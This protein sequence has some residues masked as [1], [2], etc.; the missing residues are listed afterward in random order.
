M[1]VDKKVKETYPVV[2]YDSEGRALKGVK[3]ERGSCDDCDAARVTDGKISGVQ[4]DVIIQ[5]KQAMNG[6]GDPKEG[7]PK[8]FV[9]KKVRKK[10][11][12]H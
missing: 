4:Y 9:A 6:E 12:Q 7:C 2:F 11:P 10:L 3:L 5:C 1:A 8:G